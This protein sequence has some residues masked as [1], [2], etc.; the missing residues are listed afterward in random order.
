MKKIILAIAFLTLA[1]AYQSVNAQGSGGVI[2]K[3]AR[4]L[5]RPAL[6]VVRDVA[7][8]VAG[9]AVYDRLKSRRSNSQQ[10]R[11][12]RRGPACFPPPPKSSRPIRGRN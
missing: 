8:G 4:P 7:T 1:G 5:V 12:S 3:M 10:P 11:V 2:V 6:R 9:N